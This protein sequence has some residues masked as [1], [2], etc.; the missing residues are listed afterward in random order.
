MR[1]TPPLS[2]SLFAETVRFLA[3]NSLLINMSADQGGFGEQEFWSICEISVSFIGITVPGVFNL[4][5]RALRHGPSSLFNDREYPLSQKS[6]AE[7]QRER[8]TPGLVPL[9]TSNGV[10]NSSEDEQQCSLSGTS[11][12]SRQKK[13][14]EARFTSQEMLQPKNL[15]GSI[16]VV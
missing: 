7:E 2:S 11:D 15:S 8:S 1:A 12:S 4:V 13:E 6:W 16:L 3:Y 14:E 10:G 9:S 5:K